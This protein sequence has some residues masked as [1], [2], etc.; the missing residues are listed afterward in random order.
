M[1]CGCL[2]NTFKLQSGRVDAVRHFACC[3]F[4]FQL[5]SVHVVQTFVMLMLCGCPLDTF[6]LQSGRVDTMRHLTCCVFQ[7]Q[8]GHVDTMRHFACWVCGYYETLCLLCVSVTKV[9]V[10]IL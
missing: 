6:K 1:L 4:H 9:G 10:W 3:V 7:L 8:S 2:L 5:Q